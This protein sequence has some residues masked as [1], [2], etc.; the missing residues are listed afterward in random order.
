MNADESANRPQGIDMIDDWHSLSVSPTGEL[1]VLLS[2]T[3]ENHVVCLGTVADDWGPLALDAERTLYVRDDTLAELLGALESVNTD[4]L[5]VK[6][7][8]SVLPTGAATG[9]KQDDIRAA[10]E[11]LLP[12][13]GVATAVLQQG[14]IDRVSKSLQRIN[15]RLYG[16]VAANGVAVGTNIVTGPAVPV[17]EYYIINQ[18]GATNKTSVC[19]HIDGGIENSALVFLTAGEV[20]P[21][22]WHIVNIPGP[23]LIEIP[24]KVRVQFRGCTAGDNLAIWWTGW[25]LN[26]S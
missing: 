18:I 26:I 2:A 12:I 6:V 16:T 14:I 5:L 19:T 17:G 21:P 22:A 1:I 13:G 15:V 20:N 23:F 7:E 9:A 8:A 24:D 10:I 25:S 11:A 3:G 4:S